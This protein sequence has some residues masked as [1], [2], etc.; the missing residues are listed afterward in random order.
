[1]IFRVMVVV[2]WRSCCEVVSCDGHG[3]AN[4]AGERVYLG[5]DLYKEG[6]TAPLAT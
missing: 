3:G 5:G 2:I 6:I 1:M 4:I